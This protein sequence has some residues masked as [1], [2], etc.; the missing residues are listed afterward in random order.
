MQV[1]N[2]LFFFYRSCALPQST[3]LQ[4]TGKNT[5]YLEYHSVC[6]FVCIGTPHPLSRKRVCPSPRNQDGGGHTGRR[7]R[8]FQFRRLEKKLSTLSSLWVRR[9]ASGKENRIVVTDRSHFE[10][11]EEL[12]LIITGISLPHPYASIR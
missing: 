9:C 5:K 3:R 6:P 1:Y 11:E 2:S 12:S 8:G 4:E 10:R 7:V